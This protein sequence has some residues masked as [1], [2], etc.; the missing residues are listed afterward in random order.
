MRARVPVLVFLVLLLPLQAHAAEIRLITP[1]AWPGQQITFAF[2][3]MPG[4]EQDW[5]TIVPAEADDTTWG[6]YFYTESAIGGVHSFSAQEPGEY[7]IRAYADWPDGG[8]QVIARGHVEV[9][10][11]PLSGDPSAFLRLNLNRPVYR[12]DE[13]ITVFWA[14]MPD[15]D[16]NWIALYRSGTE[17]DAYQAWEWVQGGHGSVTFSGLK[18]GD[19]EARA[20]LNWAGCGYTAQAVVPFQVAG[21]SDV[22]PN[23]LT[24]RADQLLPGDSVAADY[25]AE[26]LS[27]NAWVGVV[28]AATP[29]GSEAVNQGARLGYQTLPDGTG[30]GSLSFD[31]PDAPG[32]YELRMFD[33]D[34]NGMEVAS[35]GFEVLEQEILH[36]DRPSYL[37]GET[38]TVRAY[39][40]DPSKK[41]DVVLV[42]ASLPVLDE[43]PPP[44]DLVIHLENLAQGE[45]FEA[46]QAAPPVAGEYEIR[47]YRDQEE[48]DAVVVTVLAKTSLALDKSHFVLGEP[49]NVDWSLE[50]RTGD[51]DLR[52][53]GQL[54]LA[55]LAPGQQVGDDSYHQTLARL[56]VQAGGRGTDTLDGPQE[57]G[58][59]EIRLQDQTGDTVA[60]A[61]LTVAQT[62]YIDM[63]ET[64]FDP[65]V[66]MRVPYHTDYLPADAW[67]GIVPGDVRES[68]GEAR[69]AALDR[70]QVAKHGPGLASFT[71]PRE[72][73]KYQLRIYSSESDGRLLAVH[74]FEVLNPGNSLRLDPGTIQSGQSIQVHFTADRELAAN[75]WVG[76]VPA[77]TPHDDESLAQD[78]A[79]ERTFLKNSRTG[80]LRFRAPDVPGDYEM[81]MFSADH[82]G[83]EVAKIG[84]SVE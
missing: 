24:M 10:C 56:P 76:I 81:R 79:L 2:S 82:G 69:Q 20:F 11:T 21:A 51:A 63:T 37:L 15:F 66:P 64:R 34:F 12:P 13:E 55:G 26:G 31:L 4:N 60:S 57:P 61:E 50:K 58:R 40:P 7:E 49:I 17:D 43:V 30:S 67:L 54:V 59:Y 36:V 14:G 5:I 83:R 80:V 22:G 47:L 23:S 25:H 77:S 42:P 78:S 9:T 65:D 71:S 72:P 62:T 32:E 8:F 68:E 41:R 45:Q 52:P 48:V 19:Y 75:A 84:F 3:N 29:H 39:L 27:D 18:P 28:P 53:N 46:R 6:E 74:D 1:H 16:D 73:G 38:M 35:A 33:T 44:S 70:Q